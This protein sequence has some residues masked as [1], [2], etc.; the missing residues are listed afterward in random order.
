MNCLT[1]KINIAIEEAQKGDHKQ[2]LGCVIF[3]KKKIISKGHNSCLKSVKNLH[4]KYQKWP[5]SVHAEVDAIIKAKTDLK[6]CDMLIVRIN[7]NKQLRLAKPCESCMNYIK[8]IGI[9]KIY[10]T[11]SNYPY[12]QEEKI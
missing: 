8:Y 10:Y 9:H 12:I 1:P 2:M 7:K 5:G 6:G 11:I 3:N 4:P